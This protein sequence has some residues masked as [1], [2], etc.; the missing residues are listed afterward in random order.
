MT[1][2]CCVIG[3]INFQNDPRRIRGDL[4]LLPPDGV[5]AGIIILEKLCS[6][7]KEFKKKKKKM[8]FQIYPAY[9]GHGLPYFPLTSPLLALEPG[10]PTNH[11]NIP[12][13]HPP[14]QAD[15]QKHT[16]QRS[17]THIPELV[18]EILRLIEEE[19]CDPV[20]PGC[21]EGCVCVCLI[22]GSK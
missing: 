10:P 8:D 17:H 2:L 12:N 6:L 21:G 15:R 5:Y 4:T 7:W 16:L 22:L 14:T 20:T 19:E 13:T 1:H 11:R 9:C 18:C 3:C